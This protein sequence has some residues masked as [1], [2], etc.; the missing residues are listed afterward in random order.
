MYG[1]KITLE[2]LKYITQG[3]CR[4]GIGLQDAKIE[5]IGKEFV[6]KDEIKESDYIKFNT[7]KLQS[8]KIEF[9][10]RAANVIKFELG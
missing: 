1:E 6:L 5:F 7:D 3:L 2:D 10:N 8:I 4:I 9:N